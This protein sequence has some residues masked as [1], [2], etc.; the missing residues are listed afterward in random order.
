MNIQWYPGHMTK[1]KRA[2]TEDLRMVSLVIE[3]ADARAP[4]GSRNPDIDRMAAG[5]DRLILLN[6]A[7]L[8]DPKANEVWAKWYE[9]RGIR[10]VLTDSRQMKDIR[11]L[12][13]GARIRR[14]RH[15]RDAC[16]EGWMYEC[17]DRWERR[18]R[19]CHRL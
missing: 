12:K 3:L 10:A 14:Q 19:A 8:A 9:S 11:R 6:K 13:A 15:G 5:K 18:Q 7:D 4:Y 17:I 1:A 16:R 2:M